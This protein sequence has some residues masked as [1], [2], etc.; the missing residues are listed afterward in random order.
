MNHP[1]GTALVL[2]CIAAGPAAL[3]GE[4]CAAYPY[5]D[6]PAELSALAKRLTKTVAPHPLL[7]KALADQAPD[8]CLSDTLVEEQAY[9][10]PAAN[11]IVVNSA[12]DQDFQLT[13]LI[14]EVRHVEQHRNATC[15]TV[16]YRLEEYIRARLAFEAD[17]AAIGVYVAWKLRQGGE[18]GPW[19]K[20]S[21]WPTHRDL[22]SRFAREIAAGAG[23]TAA[24][25]ATFA[26]WYEDAERQ[27][28]YRFAICSNYLDALDR[29]KVP[30]GQDRLPADFAVRLCVMPDGRPYDCTLP[31]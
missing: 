17:A 12:L 2:A 9:F 27:D 1:G 15:P 23:E 25:S 24:T 21:A 19:D 20:L 4:T 13:I 11:R 16:A 29:E 3:A 30:D 22:V 31:P 14:H 10:E 28:I 5:A 7:A 8:L 26:Q 18:S 6:A